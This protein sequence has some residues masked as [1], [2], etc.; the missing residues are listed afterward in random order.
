MNLKIKKTLQVLTVLLASILVSVS[1]KGKESGS[2]LSNAEKQKALTY[3]QANCLSCHS[4][5]AARENRIAPPMQAVKLH[6]KTDGVR[7]KQFVE[8]V[9][10]F[11]LNP[12]V[13]KSKMPGAVRQFKLMPKMNYSEEELTL[14][15]RYI[16]RTNLETPEW[17]EGHMTAE[18]QSSDNEE[19]L[20]PLM[21]GKKIALASKALLGSNLTKAIQTQGTEEAVVFCNEQAIPLTNSSAEKHNAEVRRVSDKPR[22]P[23]NNANPEELKYIAAAKQML[24]DGNIKPQISEKNGMITGYYPIVTNQSCLQCHGTSGDIASN[25]SKKIATLYPDDKATGYKKNELRGIWVIQ[26]KK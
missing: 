25:V 23:K 22:N 21:R 5:S 16:Y 18:M 24:V 1:C 8:E 11:A 2:Q 15:A 14:V 9:V 12:S 7:E 13:E 26:F 4:P 17:L 3:L 10:A 6:Y 19:D 20:P